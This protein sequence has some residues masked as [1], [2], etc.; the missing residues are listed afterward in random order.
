MKIKYSWATSR[1]NWLRG[2]KNQRFKGHICPRLQGADVS[3]VRVE[4]TLQLMVSQSV[5]VTSP[6]WDS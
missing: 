3:G 1:V 6:I 5:L 4:V 2:E